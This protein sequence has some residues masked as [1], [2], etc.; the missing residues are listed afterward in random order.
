MN[1]GNY[2]MRLAEDVFSFLNATGGVEDHKNNFLP[3]DIYKDLKSG[4]MIFEFAVAGYDPKEISIKFLG[5][6]LEIDYD[7]SCE[8][9]K[10]DEMAFDFFK[11]KI[12]KRSF[13]VRY[14]L[15]AGHFDTSKA[16]ASYKNGI[17]KIE[18]PSSEY[19]KPRDVKVEIK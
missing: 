1:E 6:K 14:A 10:D 9:G 12:A 17:L 13:H 5:D 19:V 7:L 11:R 16:D 4:A 18:I 3:T 8:N 15:V 2:G